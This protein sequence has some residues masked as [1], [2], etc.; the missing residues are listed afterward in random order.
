M[1]WRTYNAGRRDEA[2]R[3]RQRAQ[4][5]EAALRTVTGHKRAELLAELERI[6]AR[7]PQA[8]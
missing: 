1:G 6:R 5:L 7:L 4:R 8:I 3:D 2:E